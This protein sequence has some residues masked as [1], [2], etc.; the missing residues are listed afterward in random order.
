MRSLSFFVLPVIIIAIAGF[1]W[2]LLRSAENS[3]ALTAQEVELSPWDSLTSDEISRASAS[4]KERHGED[5]VFSRI[6]L[7]QPNK[8]EALAWKSGQ[9]A[10]R[11]AEITFRINKQGFVSFFDLNSRLPTS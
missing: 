9:V 11:E 1:G 2:V 10:A 4:V 6:S 7:R 3:R 8:S 5:V